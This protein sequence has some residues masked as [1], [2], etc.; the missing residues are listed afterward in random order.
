MVSY[1]RNDTLCKHSLQVF[2]TKDYQLLI[3]ITI[4]LVLL[5]YR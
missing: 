2:E 5:W 1:R 4:S 3:T